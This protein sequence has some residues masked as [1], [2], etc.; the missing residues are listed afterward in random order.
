MFS[1]QQLDDGQV[2]LHPC[3]VC[4]LCTWSIAGCVSILCSIMS[5]FHIKYFLIWKYEYEFSH[6]VS[7]IEMREV[8]KVLFTRELILWDD[9]HVLVTLQNIWAACNVNQPRS[10][11]SVFS[12]SATLLYY[13]CCNLFAKFMPPVEMHHPSLWTWY[14][15]RTL[16]FIRT[17]L[18]LLLPLC[19]THPLV[20]FCFRRRGVCCREAYRGLDQA[21]G[22]V[23][24]N[25]LDFCSCQP[26]LGFSCLWAQFHSWKVWHGGLHWEA[27]EQNCRGQ[28]VSGLLCPHCYSAWSCVC[29]C[30]CITAK[31]QG[32]I[33]VSCAFI[34]S[35]IYVRGFIHPI[36]QQEG[37]PLYELGPAQGFFLLKR[38][39]FLTTV[40]LGLRI[41]VSLKQH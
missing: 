29:D 21:D 14:E 23:S 36:N 27:V 7:C 12:Y 22:C 28:F 31:L 41:W 10:E 33:C 5:Q 19:S 34:S 1:P 30:C 35:K 32:Q 37:V 16:F 15:M 40:A 3:W 6:F 17:F 4:C 38:Q 11:S 24:W 18:N 13:S 2:E 39:F 9:R 20:T 26:P 25:Q 8:R